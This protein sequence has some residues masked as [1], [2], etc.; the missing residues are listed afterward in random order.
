MKSFA[1]LNVQTLALVVAVVLASATFASAA[2]TLR[3]FPFPGSELFSGSVACAVRNGGTGTPDGI[4]VK[5]NVFDSD[6]TVLAS[7]QLFMQ[8]NDADLG[9]AV[10]LRTVSPAMCECTMPND[11]LFTCSLIYT[12]GPIHA[13]VPSQ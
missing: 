7:D 2:V 3:T 13:V 10:D 6:G 9:T 5:V 1:T 11:T 8:A 4:S 12:N